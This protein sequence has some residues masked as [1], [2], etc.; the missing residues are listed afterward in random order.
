VINLKDSRRERISVARLSVPKSS[1]QAITAPD[2]VRKHDPKRSNSTHKMVTIA[3]AKRLF[4]ADNNTSEGP[5]TC[6]KTEAGPSTLKVIAKPL[7]PEHL[8]DEVLLVVP[9]M[10]KSLYDKLTDDS[11][12]EP[13][14]SENE[15]DIQ[16]AEMKASN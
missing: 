2:E 15:R 1:P 14:S 10:P 6:A 8:P 4:E 7:R 11:L 9:P 3:G 12:T 16:K 13:E 5:S